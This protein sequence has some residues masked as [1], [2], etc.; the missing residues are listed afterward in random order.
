MSPKQ[1]STR[2]ARRPSTAQIVFLA[3]TVVIILSFVLSLFVQ[4]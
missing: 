3:L 2:G 4:V 1:T